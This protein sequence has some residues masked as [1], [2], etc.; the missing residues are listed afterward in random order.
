MEGKPR[1][2]GRSF[3]KWLPSLMK[4]LCFQHEHAAQFACQYLSSPS[5]PLLRL[6]NYVTIQ[7]TLCTGLLCI[8]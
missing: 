1:F 2:K 3:Y 4:V 8:S 5:G 6:A 7:I